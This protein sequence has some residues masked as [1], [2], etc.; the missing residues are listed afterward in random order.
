[1]PTAVHLIDWWRNPMRD[2]LAG[3]CVKS[4]LV[5]PGGLVAEPGLLVA[6]PDAIS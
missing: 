3:A 4:G 6:E 1:M 5:E 2:Q